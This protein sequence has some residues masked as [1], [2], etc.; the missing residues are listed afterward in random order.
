MGMGEQDTRYAKSGEVHLAYQVT[1]DGPVDVV[2]IPGFISHVELR[3][4]EP[5]LARFLRQLGTFT[6]LIAFDKRGMGLSDRDPN[7]RTPTL[8]Q[9]VGD[10]SA[11]MDAAGCP[12][13][14]LFAW[15]EGGATA[16]RFALTHP[17]RVAALILVG[18]TPRFCLEPDFPEGIP[19]ELLTLAVQTWQR[20]WGTGV[21]LALYGPSVV[22]DARFAS[23]WAGYQRHSASPGSMASSLRMQW[24]VDVRTDLPHLTIPTLVLHRVDDMVIPVT[25]ARY[26]AA[27][28]LG[29][30]YR[31]M[32]G[33]D[34]MY[35]LGDQIAS[36]EYIRE[37]LAGAIEGVSVKQRR[38][39][40]ST[41]WESLT[42]RELEVARS[43]GDG[44]T[45]KQIAEQFWLS[46]R[47]IQSHVGNVL[48]K[49]DLANRS[50]IAAEAARRFPA[51]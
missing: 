23:W 33:S 45:N 30:H 6:R 32:P 43:I 12:R 16:I 31:E 7:E 48:A 1:G 2:M 21:A 42:P 35:W 36:I 10:V 49:L 15:S 3:W 39:R 24:G 38:R 46:P 11:V 41:G 13:A 25:C 47:T 28:I 14:A 27:N 18:T 44:L 50:E 5:A 26:M 51:P 8:A 29:A 17:S 4:R 37:F 9:R 40:T 19:L 34:H 20:D 22:D